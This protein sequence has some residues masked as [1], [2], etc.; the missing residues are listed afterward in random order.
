MKR[1]S[2]VLAFLCFTTTV[3]AALGGR[4]DVASDPQV[5][6]LRDL[7][8][9][10]WLV[11]MQK[12]VW[13]LVNFKNGDDVLHI[14]FFVASRLEGQYPAYGPSLGTNVGPLAG[15][16][17]EK[18]SLLRAVSDATPPWLGKLADWTSF[19]VFGGYRPRISSDEHHW[20]WG[21]GGQVRIPLGGVVDWAR[22]RRDVEGLPNEKG[23]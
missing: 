12:N 21:V 20:M 3:H 15:S 13:K 1:F 10:L 2:A 7:K 23:L 8:D 9:G 16:L 17:A 11:G 22:G 4:L 5:I 19:D 6:G 14:S 18:I